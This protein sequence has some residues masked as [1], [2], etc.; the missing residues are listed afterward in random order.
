MIQILCL[1]ACLLG[2]GDR[3][4]ESA[5]GGKG[6]ICP[7]GPD[8]LRIWEPDIT[9]SDW[10][11]DQAI[12]LEVQHDGCTT[13]EIDDTWQT[14][15]HALIELTD[16]VSGE[17]LE[18]K[19]NQ[20]LPLSDIVLTPETPFVADSTY[21]IMLRPAT[22]QTAIE[23][24]EVGWFDP[25]FIVTGSPACAFLY[26]QSRPV[27]ARIEMQPSEYGDLR[28][29]FNSSEGLRWE[30]LTGKERPQLLVD[31]SDLTICQGPPSCCIPGTAADGGMSADT[32]CDELKSYTIEHDGE[33][34]Q[35]MSLFY[36]VVS[37]DIRGTFT[38]LQLTVPSTLAGID[39]TVADAVYGIPYAALDGD[40]VVYTFARDQF[41]PTVKYLLW[42]PPCE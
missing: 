41:R 14:A 18:Y 42:T 15:I 24:L 8:S 22:A 36:F 7:D 32:P 28:V 17:G 3:T 40:R 35:A 30:G 39:A 11:P 4:A 10:P 16:M 1:A 29:Y 12:K 19:V 21:R 25:W 20:G 6:V 9:R 37:T 38:T 31:G 26:T 34:I 23:G 13:P 27:V 2:C 5:D 33:S